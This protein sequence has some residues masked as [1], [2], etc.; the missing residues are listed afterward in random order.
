MVEDRCSY[1]KDFTKEDI[2]F[3]NQLPGILSFP[4][5]N[6]IVVHAGLVPGVQF[7]KQTEENLTQM[8]NVL[9]DNGIPKGIKD[10]QENCVPWASTWNGPDH[11]YFGHDAKRELQV[12]IYYLCR[13]FFIHCLSCGHSQLD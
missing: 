9:M 11:V 4:E 13:L 2:A 12:Y 10:D 7:R 3:L 6:A 8:R 5:L 1:V